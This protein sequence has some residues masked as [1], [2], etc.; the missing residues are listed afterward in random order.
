MNNIFDEQMKEALAIAKNLELVQE[1][2]LAR[3]M[4]IKCVEKAANYN[5][6]DLIALFYGMSAYEKIRD[7]ADAVRYV[8]VAKCAANVYD[9]IARVGA[10]SSAAPWAVRDSGHSDRRLWDAFTWLQM[11]GRGV[12]SGD[13]NQFH[14]LLSALGANERP[15]FNMTD[16]IAQFPLLDIIKGLVSGSITISNTGELR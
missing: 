5:G 7:V 15:H 3:V 9:M 6:E 13:V 16:R 12:E 11:R 2:E 4:G 8:F 10:A 1:K 14:Q